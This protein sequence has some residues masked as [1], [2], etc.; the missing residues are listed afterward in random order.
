LDAAGDNQTSSTLEDSQTR[1]PATDPRMLVSNQN[2]VQT[3]VSFGVSQWKRG[4]GGQD[5]SGFE[6]PKSM[7]P[8]TVIDNSTYPAE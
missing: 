1:L 5:A 6:V 2:D 4:R 7:V 8:V 3:P